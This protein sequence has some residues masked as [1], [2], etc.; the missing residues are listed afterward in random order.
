MKINPLVHKTIENTYIRYVSN[1]EK[2]DLYFAS[3]YSKDLS[4]VHNSI[5]YLDVQ[6][7]IKDLKPSLLPL[8]TNNNSANPRVYVGLENSRIGFF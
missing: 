5:M 3:T 2:L 8:I 7:S 6:A 4:Q 1:N